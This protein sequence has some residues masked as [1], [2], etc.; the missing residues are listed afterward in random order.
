MPGSFGVGDVHRFR[1]IGV[2]GQIESANEGIGTGVNDGYCTGAAVG[3]NDFALRANARITGACRKDDEQTKTNDSQY[4]E[5][6]F[7]GFLLL[8]SKQ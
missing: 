1:G 6:F 5:S 2:G 8:S 4:Q 3:D 7:H